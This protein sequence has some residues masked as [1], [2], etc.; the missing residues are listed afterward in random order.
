[1][2]FLDVFLQLF[3]GYPQAITRGNGHSSSKI[4]AYSWEWLD[5]IRG[6]SPIYHI[7]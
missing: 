4:E 5:D 2:I 6:Y 1:M 7:P 3:T